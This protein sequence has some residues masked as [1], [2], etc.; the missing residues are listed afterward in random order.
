MIA[1]LD[2]G[3]VSALAPVDERARARLRALRSEAEDLVVPAGV[4]AEGLLT[5]H[6]QRDFHVRRLLELTRIA[7]IDAGLG[8]AAGRLRTAVVAVRPARPPSGVDALVVAAVAVDQASA[9][10]VVLVTSDVNDLGR[11]LS[12]AEARRVTVQRV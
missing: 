2:S 9:D 1:V 7:D 6:P 12:E 8:F 4:L 10:D 3:A 5:G 11:L